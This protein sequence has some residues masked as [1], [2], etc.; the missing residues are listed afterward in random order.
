MHL[1]MDNNSFVYNNQNYKTRLN[2][3]HQIENDILAI[4]VI[5]VMNRKGDSISLD[6]I[7]KGIALTRQRAR[8]DKICE[9]PYVIV[10]GAHNEDGARCLVKGINNYFNSY[11][12][13]WGHN[14]S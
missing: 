2:G 5:E 9:K 6:S 3:E 13:Y 14:K 12:C 4:T 8:M 1:E 7:K 11:Y 10:D